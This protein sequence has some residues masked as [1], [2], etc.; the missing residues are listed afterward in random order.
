MFELVIIWILFGIVTGAIAEWRGRSGC[1]WGCLGVLLGPFGVL[2]ALV[3][4][5]ENENLGKMKCP[6]CAE[7]IQ[8]EARVCRYCGRN[9]PQRCDGDL[10]KYER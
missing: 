7:W 1:G 8:R 5:P 9:L 3:S 2:L 4:P 10:M 6:H